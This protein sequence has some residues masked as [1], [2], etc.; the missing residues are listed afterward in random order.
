MLRIVTKAFFIVI[1][2]WILKINLLN[3][4]LKIM[5]L[6]KRFAFFNDFIINFKNLFKTAICLKISEFAIREKRQVLLLLK[7]RCVL[8]LKAWK[9]WK[10][11]RL[12]NNF[13]INWKND[14]WKE[15]W[16]K[17]KC[18]SRFDWKFNFAEFIVL[19]ESDALIKLKV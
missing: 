16:W 1:V 19:K 4:N 14:R 13:D 9:I 5:L 6:K 8:L 3:K 12:R 15:N 18:D 10:K 7:T 17:L 11:N 2:I